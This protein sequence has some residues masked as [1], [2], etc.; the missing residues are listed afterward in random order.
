MIQVPEGRLNPHT[1]FA[2]G[3][4]VPQTA[5]ACTQRGYAKSPNELNFSIDLHRKT[6]YYQ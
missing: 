2:G 5:S 6:Y 3:E 1:P 4:I